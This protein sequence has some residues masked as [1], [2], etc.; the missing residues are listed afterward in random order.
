MTGWM[1]RWQKC[2]FAAAP[3]EQRRRKLEICGKPPMQRSEEEDGE[4]GFG[5][6]DDVLFLLP[7]LFVI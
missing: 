7:F 5:R 4:R 6:G 3:A 1:K 2:W